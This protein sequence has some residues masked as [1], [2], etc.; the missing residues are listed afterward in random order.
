MAIIQSG[1]SNE[2]SATPLGGP[3]QPDYTNVHGHWRAD[4]LQ[5]AGLADGASVASWPDQTANGFHLAPASGAPTLR[6]DRVAGKPAVELLGSSQQI[7]KTFGVPGHIFGDYALLM[8]G[9]SINI[10]TSSH[11]ILWRLSA[12]HTFRSLSSGVWQYGSETLTG[13]THTHFLERNALFTWRRVGATGSVKRDGTLLATG[14]AVSTAEAQLFE[15]PSGTLHQCQWAEI[16]L[17]KN[18]TA[19]VITAWEEFLAD[20]YGFTLAS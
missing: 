1:Y 8:V 17:L 15:V 7:V 16:V 5:E 12:T 11:Q 20:K 3:V 6:Y 2:V 4:Q 14:T 9:K 18:P 10:S 13:A 19:G